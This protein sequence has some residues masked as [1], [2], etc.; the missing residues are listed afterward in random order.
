M[1]KHQNKVNWNTNVKKITIKN[2]Q[3]RLTVDKY[4]QLKIIS[5]LG[6]DSRK[7][8]NLKQLALLNVFFF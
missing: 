4:Y 1:I 3:M 5:S 7:K 8:N 2:E 6:M